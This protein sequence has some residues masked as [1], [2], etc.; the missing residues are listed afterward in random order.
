MKEPKDKSNIIPFP[1]KEGASQELGEIHIRLDHGR[2]SIQTNLSP[3]FAL[4]LLEV[5][6]MEFIDCF[7]E[8]YIAL[9]TDDETLH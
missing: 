4:P 9:R 3:V 7:L 1:L 2:L 5:V 8:Q 6:K